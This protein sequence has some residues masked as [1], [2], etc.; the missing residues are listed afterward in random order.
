M[1][2]RNQNWETE[3]L[4]TNKESAEIFFKTKLIV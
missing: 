3:N 4:V 1:S 2:R